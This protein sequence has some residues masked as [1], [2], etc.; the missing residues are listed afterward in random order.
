M[1]ASFS[2]ITRRQVLA[3]TVGAASALTL[4]ACGA[5]PVAPSAEAPITEEKPAA[6]PETEVR[7]ITISNYHSPEDPRWTAISETYRI[8]EEALGIKINTTP[9]YREVNTKARH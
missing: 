1:T 2:T 5:V 8:G 4:A 7:E 3:A 9:E 6:A